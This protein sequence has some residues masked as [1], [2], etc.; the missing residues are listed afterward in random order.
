[1]ILYTVYITVPNELESELAKYMCDK[2][3]PDVMATGR[4]VKAEFSKSDEGG[5]RTS[6]TAADRT[7]L[8][9]YLKHDTERLREAFARE[10][11]YKVSAKREVWESICTVPGD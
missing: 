7:S 3:I 5:F 1:M 8:E 10:F 4:F 2:H 11:P 9:L 6:Y